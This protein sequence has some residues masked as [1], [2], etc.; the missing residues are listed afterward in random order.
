[1]VFGESLEVRSVTHRTSRREFLKTVGA[2]AGAAGLALGASHALGKLPPDIDEPMPSIRDVPKRKLGRTGIELAPL[3]LGLAAL[4]QAFYPPDE[5]EPVVHAAIDAGIQYLDVA[6]NY[7]VGEER[8]GPVLARRRNEVFLVSKVEPVAYRKDDTIKLIETSL[9]KMQ[10]DHLDVCHV[11]NV[12]DFTPEQI[13]NKGSCLDGIEEAKKRGLVK[14]VGISGHYKVGRLVPVLETGR[15]DVMMCVLN[16]VDRFV[17]NFEERVLPT[18]RKH[19]T[20]IV[21]MKVLG[22]ASTMSYINRMPGAL[23]SPEHYRMAIRYAMGLPDMANVVIGMKSMGELR[24]A[25]KVTRDFKPLT[26]AEREWIDQEGKLLADKWKTRYG[27]I[28]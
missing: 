27:P 23:S 8:L 18:A 25:L 14:H 21:A 13:L 4:G 26:P 10:T 16:F 22:G 19:G 24:A 2:G 15:I 17:Y 9:R 6:P 7:C 5:Y 1:V 20:A 3:G 12:G 28:D 11:H